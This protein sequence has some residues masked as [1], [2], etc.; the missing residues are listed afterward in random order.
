M[1]KIHKTISALVLVGIM[2]I[3]SLGYA[4]AQAMR[5]FPKIKAGSNNS[6]VRA[7]QT[8]LLN[9]NAKTREL[10]I[11]SG[12]VDE[13]FGAKTEEALKFFQN[14]RNIGVDGVCGSESW[15]QFRKTI[16][17]NGKRGS[18]T[19]Y[20]GLNPYKASTHNMG[21]GVDDHYWYTTWR[22]NRDE[23]G[24]MIVY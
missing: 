16:K 4:N 24:W 23:N 1:K 22:W 3:S 12:G 5:D 6:Y 13:K 21:K 17:E 2:S 8:M 7:M 20:V 19:L 18:L 11:S 15:N 10:I 9:Y 14:R